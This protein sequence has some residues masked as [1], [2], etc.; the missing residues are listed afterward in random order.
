MTPYE[1]IC[2]YKRIKGIKSDN[3][4]AKELGVTRSAISM[5]KS[6][7]GFSVE[8]AWKVSETLSLDPAEVI[9]TCELANAKRSGDEGKIQVWKKR[10]RAVS[11]SAASVFFGSALLGGAV[12][13]VRH[14]ILC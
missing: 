9:A 3:A 2:E 13:A 10:F 8:T 14:C 5:I 1:M 4:V 6:G 7:G 11:H 12:E